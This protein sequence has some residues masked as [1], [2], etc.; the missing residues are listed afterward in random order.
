MT[1]IL[2]RPSTTGKQIGYLHGGAQVARAEKPFSNNNCAGGWYPIRP[3]GFVCAS[4]TATTD[5]AHPTLA[6]MSQ[7]PKLD[8][9]APWM[10]AQTKPSRNR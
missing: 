3:R 5:L 10:R 1:P 9:P 7:Q 2:D 8:A 6:A 4:E